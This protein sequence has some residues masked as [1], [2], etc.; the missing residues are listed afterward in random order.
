M[1]KASTYVAVLAS[2]AAAGLGGAV[3]AGAADRATGTTPGTTPKNGDHRGGPGPG[4]GAGGGPLGLR[5][6]PE[7]GEAIAAIA[8]ALGVSEA[9]L[10]AALKDARPTP[11]TEAE[12]AAKLDERAAALAKEL[13]EST[14]DVKAVIESLRDEKAEKRAERSEKRAEKGKEAGRPGGD[15]RGPRP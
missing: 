9:Q 11:P 15:D 1:P 2:T 13:G 4:P 8:K 12:R 6:G 7:R 3:I 10:Q 5:G 14:A